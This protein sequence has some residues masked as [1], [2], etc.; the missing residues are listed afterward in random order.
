M[1]M[2]EED[3]LSVIMKNRERISA[4]VWVMLKDTQTS[5]DIFQNVALKALTKNVTFETEDHILSWCF[6]TARREAI[7]YIRKHKRMTTGIE[8]AVM[9]LL[10]SE[11]IKETKSKGN[12]Q[13]DA[14][15][16]CIEKVPENSKD[17]LKLRYFEGHSCSEVGKIIG[18]GLDAVYKRLS[19]LHKSI[20]KCMECKL[21][22]SEPEKA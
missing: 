22:E 21:E 12:K 16:D 4:A 14:L 6:I 8:P 13:I 17:L 15:R 2:T 5:E 19:R 10:E 18:L 1:K 3:I 9:E 20:K 7:D 11:W